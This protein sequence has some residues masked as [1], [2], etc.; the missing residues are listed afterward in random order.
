MQST[1]KQQ[2]FFDFS[3]PISSLYFLNNFPI[4]LFISAFVHKIF[5]KYLTNMQGIV[6]SVG[7]IAVNQTKSY[8][9]KS[10]ISE[11]ITNKYISKHLT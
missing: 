8:P 2:D 9:H 7:D 5:F 1:Y 11:Q 10:D 6:L 3:E 4:S